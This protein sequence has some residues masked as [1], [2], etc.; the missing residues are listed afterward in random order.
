MNYEGDVRCWIGNGILVN[1]IEGSSRGNE[2]P[3]IIPE[4]HP[5]VFL[6]TLLH[7]ITR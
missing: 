6:D 7:L 1:F 3:K 2:C 5:F 4:L